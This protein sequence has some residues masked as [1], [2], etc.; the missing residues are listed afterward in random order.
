M[1]QTDNIM[2]KAIDIVDAGTELTEEQLQDL[3]Q[4]NHLMEDVQDI[5][6][7]KTAMRMT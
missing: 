2:E 1:E 5:L 6:N 7:V 3:R 4:D